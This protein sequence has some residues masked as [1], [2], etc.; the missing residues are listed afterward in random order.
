MA[1]QTLGY[2]LANEGEDSVLFDINLLANALLHLQH[3]RKN[4]LV[5]AVKFEQKKRDWGILTIQV[6][7]V[8]EASTLIPDIAKMVASIKVEG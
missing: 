2:H 5:E 4:S 3:G 6:K 8:V 1:D 7:L